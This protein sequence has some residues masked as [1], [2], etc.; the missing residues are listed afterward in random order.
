MTTHTNLAAA[1]ADGDLPC[2]LSPMASAPVCERSR[3]AVVAVAAESAHDSERNTIFMIAL[4]VVVNVVVIA[5]AVLLRA[6]Q[7]K[8]LCGARLVVSRV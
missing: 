6:S 2:F 5:F 1:S 8:K 7:E 4:V 3:T